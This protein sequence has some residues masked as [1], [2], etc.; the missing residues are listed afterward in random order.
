MMMNQDTPNVGEAREKQVTCDGFEIFDGPSL[1]ITNDK[2]DGDLLIKQMHPLVERTLRFGPLKTSLSD[3]MEKDNYWLEC[4][5]ERKQRIIHSTRPVRVYLTNGIDR[6]KLYSIEWSKMQI[7]AKIH[8]QYDLAGGIPDKMNL[9]RTH[10]S[11]LYPKPIIQRVEVKTI[12]ER[13]PFEVLAE[14]YPR[15]RRQA[16]TLT[17]MV[18]NRT[19]GERLKDLTD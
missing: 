4:L 2:E 5:V 16:I 8:G 12:I 10:S 14:R 15:K 7:A 11:A 1:E 13:D 19:L 6:Y 17:T 9:M 3:L 18:G